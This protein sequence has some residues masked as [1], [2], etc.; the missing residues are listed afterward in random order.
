MGDV[1]SMSLHLSWN[2]P[3]CIDTPHRLLKVV[4]TP[5]EALAVMSH[6]WPDGARAPSYF[7][8][9]RA[10]IAALC[11]NGSSHVARDKFVTACREAQIRFKLMPTLQ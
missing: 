8:A 10:C 2:A 4:R 11:G 7:S 5:D 9:K 6:S 1:L 3:I